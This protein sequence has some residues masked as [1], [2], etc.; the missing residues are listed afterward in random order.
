MYLNFLRFNIVQ[1][2]ISAKNNKI[3]FITF[4]Q[5]GVL[6]ANK[7]SHFIS[8]TIK[9]KASGQLVINQVIAH[10]HLIFLSADNINS[11]LNQIKNIK[12][13]IHD[14]HKKELIIFHQVKIDDI[15]KKKIVIIQIVISSFCIESFKSSFIF[16]IYLYNIYF[17]RYYI[18]LFILAIKKGYFYVNTQ[19]NGVI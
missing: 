5:S 15:T 19:K 4:D 8:H 6:A 13:I 3:G 1:V 7:T 12:T 18:Y 9:T 10:T 16:F 17:N 2:I 14:A 11:I